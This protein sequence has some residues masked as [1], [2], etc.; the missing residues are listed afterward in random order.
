MV[1]S[2]RARE[3][4]IDFFLEGVE[5]TAD[6]AV[7]TARRLVTLFKED[8][9]RIRGLGRASVT[10]E[11]VFGTFRT[12]PLLT[13]NEVCKRSGATFPS[14]SK[15]I[16]NLIKLGIVREITGRQ[17]NRIFSYDRYLTILSEGTERL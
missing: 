6:G 14:A 12:R 2:D 4:W 11:V 16:D 5:E 8:D 1:R 17:R 7:N 13:I 9:E 15:A 3:S 10:A